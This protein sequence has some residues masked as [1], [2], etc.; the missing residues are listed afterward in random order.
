MAAKQDTY[1]ITNPVKDV[2]KLW[3]IPSVN[4]FY[5]SFIGN[6]MDQF[7]KVTKDKLVAKLKSKAWELAKKA[8]IKIGGEIAGDIIPYAKAVILI[9][10]SI[11]TTPTCNF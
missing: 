6:L 8:L 5:G 9:I 7:W 3:D 10:T 11:K 2:M 1:H 4:I